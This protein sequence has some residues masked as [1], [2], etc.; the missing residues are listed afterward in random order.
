[1]RYKNENL[2]TPTLEIPESTVQE[3]EGPDMISRVDDILRMDLFGDDEDGAD[4]VEY[5]QQQIGAEPILPSPYKRYGSAPEEKDSEIR[6]ERSTRKG[7]DKKELRRTLES[8]QSSI[9]IE[10][11]EYD[12]NST[13]KSTM[14]ST[15]NRTG[16][17]SESGFSEIR[18]TPQIQVSRHKSDSADYLSSQRNYSYSNAVRK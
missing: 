2:L 13:M 17:L 4:W 9:G 14:K 15:L 3:F 11:A 6:D 5:G 12:N 18:N 1:M 8:T 16:T 10:D 7:R